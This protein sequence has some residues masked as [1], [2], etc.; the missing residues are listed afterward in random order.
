MIFPHFLTLR[1]EKT[2]LLKFRAERGKKIFPLVFASQLTGSPSSSRVAYCKLSSECGPSKKN[3]GKEF[4]SRY[5]GEDTNFMHGE[6]EQTKKNFDQTKIIAKLNSKKLLLTIPFHRQ[7]NA[8][9]DL[10]KKTEINQGSKKKN[11]AS[12]ATYARALLA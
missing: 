11:K 12:A 8:F 6:R 1:R 3:L 4:P 9:L 7:A 10:K 5:L 2:F